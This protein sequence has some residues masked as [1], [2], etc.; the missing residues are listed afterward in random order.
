M[1]TMYE[2]KTEEMTIRVG[3]KA[4][5]GRIWY[6][7]TAEK[8]P[9][10]ICSHGYNGCHT[11]FTGEC[12]FFA[13]HGMVAYSLDFCGGSTRSR[14]TGK[15]TDMTLFTEKQDLLD[16]FDHI[17]AM[18]QVDSE[19]IFLL[20]GS[21]GGIVTALAAEEQAD[22]VRGM[23]LYFPAF[24]IPDNWRNHFGAPENIPESFEFWGLTLGKEFFTSMQDYSAYDHIGGFTGPVLI[25]QGDADAIVKPES[26][27]RAAT[28]Y[29]QAE[30][31]I[32]PGEGHGFSAEGIRFAMDSTLRLIQ[33]ASRALR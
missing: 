18:E 8:C 12:E 25:L 2:V 14:S 23:I 22:K 13:Q 5:Y 1:I 17:S 21:Q 20:G 11:D 30:L 7:V 24:G 31:V 15:S 27:Q 28:K 29:A 6:P 9:A 4:I 16:V 26:S 33:N 3:E 10:I 32:M 19:A